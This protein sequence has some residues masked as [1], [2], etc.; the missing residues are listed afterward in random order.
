MLC[1]RVITECLFGYE[2]RAAAT[3]GRR[4]TIHHG[5]AVVISKHVVAGGPIL[6]ATASPLAPNRGAAQRR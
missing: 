5:Y 2:I 1:Y 4:F 6:L 3:I